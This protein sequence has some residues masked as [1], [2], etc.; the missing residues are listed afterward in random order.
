MGSAQ[1]V[2]ETLLGCGSCTITCRES[3][4]V[5]EWGLIREGMSATLT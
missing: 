3:F 2:F 4:V 1:C 5:S